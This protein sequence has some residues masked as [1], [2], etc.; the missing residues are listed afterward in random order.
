[1]PQYFF[2]FFRIEELEIIHYFMSIKCRDAFLVKTGELVA[3]DSTEIC[4]SINSVPIIT[5]GFREG[6]NL[7]KVALVISYNITS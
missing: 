7:S 3:F 1:M 4:Q 5:T 6:L 2:F